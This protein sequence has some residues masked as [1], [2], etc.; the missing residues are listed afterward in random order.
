[1]KIRKMLLPIA[2]IIVLCISC[3]TSDTTE[4]KKIHH[5]LTEMFN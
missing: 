2:T 1:M 3:A 4:T 5:S